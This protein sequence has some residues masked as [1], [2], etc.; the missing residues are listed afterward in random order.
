MKKSGFTIIELLVTLAIIGMLASLAMTSLTASRA[1]SRDAARVSDVKQLQN[2]LQL[3]LND[4]K[5][6]PATLDPA[7]LVPLHIRAVP[8]DPLTG[9]SYSYAALMSGNRCIDY[10]LGA[11]LET[12]SAG[13]GV[14]SNDFDSGSAG[15]V[16]TGSAANFDGT[17]PVYDVRP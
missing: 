13:T 16:C 12:V 2:A 7:E 3:Y 9:A 15:T 14:L 10:H 8:R 11:T 17:D 1:K 4:N 5:Q 6:Y